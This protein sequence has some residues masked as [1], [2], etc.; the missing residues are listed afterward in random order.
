MGVFD[1]K[2]RASHAADEGAFSTHVQSKIDELLAQMQASTDADEMVV[3]AE[4]LK[5]LAQQPSD[6]ESHEDVAKVMLAYE[7]AAYPHQHSPG[8]DENGVTP[9]TA[10][11]VVSKPHRRADRKSECVCGMGGEEAVKAA[12]ILEYMKAVGEHVGV[13]HG[14]QPVYGCLYEI[15]KL[16]ACK[17]EEDA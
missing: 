12:V 17:H 1:D 15:C 2:P 14:A 9:V 16:V 7:N 5:L 10:A 11:A 13:F 4:R 6:D 3:L 8:E